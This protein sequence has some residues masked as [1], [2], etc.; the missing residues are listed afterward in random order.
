[1]SHW[2]ASYVGWPYERGAQGP[3]AWDCWSFFRRVQCEHYGRDVPLLPAPPTWRDIARAFPTWSA[4]MGWHETTAPRDGDAVF[5]ARLREPTHVGVWL[6]D[7]QATLH[8]PAGGSVLHD[9][10]HLAAGLWRVRGYY[11]PED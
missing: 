1:M 6:A 3:D 7:L 4:A 2:A 8:C 10:R 5:M 9:A 11:S